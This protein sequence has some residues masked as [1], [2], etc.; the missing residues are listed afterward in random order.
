MVF[1]N[2]HDG[3][4]VGKSVV[5]AGGRHDTESSKKMRAPDLLL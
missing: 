5:E 2:V 4:E 1:R 3:A